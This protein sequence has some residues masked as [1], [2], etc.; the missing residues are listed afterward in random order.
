MRNPPWFKTAIAGERTTSLRARWPS[1][2]EKPEEKPARLKEFDWAHWH[3]E[4]KRFEAKAV[5]RG[6]FE[7]LKR[8]GDYGVLHDGTLMRMEG[9]KE[10]RIYCEDVEGFPFGLITPGFCSMLERRMIVSGKKS[11]KRRGEREARG[12]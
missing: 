5:S 3:Y 2:H 1:D 7:A 8:F 12:S 9:N 4:G 10:F 11:L 6:E